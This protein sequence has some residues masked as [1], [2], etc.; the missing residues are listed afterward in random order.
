MRQPGVDDVAHV[1]HPE[2]LHHRARRAVDVDGLRDDGVELQDV[3]GDA[4]RLAR[5]LGG[6]AVAP[7]VGVEEPHQLDLGPAADVGV[8]QAGVADRRPSSRTVQGP[9]PQRSQWREK[10]VEER[11]RAVGGPQVLGPDLLG[12]AGVGEDPRVGGG[13][14]GLGPAAGEAGGGDAIDAEVDGHGRRLFGGHRVRVHLLGVDAREERSGVHELLPLGAVARHVD[15]Q[16]R[17]A[18]V[19]ALLG[20]WT[21]TSVARPW[22]VTESSSPGRCVA[23]TC[24]R[25]AMWRKRVESGDE[26]K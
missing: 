2:L 26:P 18:Q 9:K 8:M 13:V 24:G 15:V 4:H 22:T 6:V 12:D 3:E 11:L 23:L 25:L 21:S 1:G 17:A 14:A 10:V 7:V 16:Q 20:A 5:H 19:G